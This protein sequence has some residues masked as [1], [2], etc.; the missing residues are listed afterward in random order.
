MRSEKAKLAPMD[1]SA[2]LAMHAVNN[3]QQNLPVV[4][5]KRLALLGL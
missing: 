4:Q 2:P 1:D 3:A 5:V